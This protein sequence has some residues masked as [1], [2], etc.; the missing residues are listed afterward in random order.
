MRRLL[1][2][3]ICAAAL[4]AAAAPGNAER[5]APAK[6]AAIHEFEG[7]V[8]SV[9]RVA[10]TFRMRDHHRGVVRIRATRSTRYDELRGFSSLHRGL[11]V[12]VEA[13]RVSGAWVAREIE[14]D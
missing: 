1:T 3:V 12:D 7:P 14:R 13:R 10:R 5:L 2:A 9:D 11:R 6:A 8:L 4:L